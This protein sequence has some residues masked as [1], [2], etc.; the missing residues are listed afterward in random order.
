MQ[1]RLLPLLVASALPFVASNANASAF[2]LSEQGVSGL[3]NAYAGAAA[4]AED[5][6][7][8]WWN[9]AGMARLG[10]GMHVAFSGFAIMP[11]TNFNNSSSSGALGQTPGGNGGDAGSTAFVPNIFFAMALNPAW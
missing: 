3:G 5:A 9:P 11:S 7:T 6:S 1:K 8:V 2:A 10:S 4:T